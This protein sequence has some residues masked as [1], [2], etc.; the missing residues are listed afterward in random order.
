MNI[1]PLGAEHI[2]NK[3]SFNQASVIFTTVIITIVI[4]RTQYAS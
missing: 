1:M 2:K 4:F 3:S